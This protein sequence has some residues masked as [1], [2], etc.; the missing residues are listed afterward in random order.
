MEARLFN[1]LQLSA[2]VLRSGKAL[3]VFPE[4]SRSRDGRLKDFKKGVAIIAKELNIPLVPVA[5]TG[6]YDMM[7]AGRLL[8]RPARVSVTFGKPVH[9]AGMSYDEITQRL[10]DEVAR[11]L[12]PEREGRP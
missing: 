10:R 8:P 7:K 3:C 9:P 12:G 11:M 5:L 6:T 2:H 1:A 4:G